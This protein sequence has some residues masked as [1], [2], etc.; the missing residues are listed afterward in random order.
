MKLGIIS[1]IRY[2]S[3]ASTTKTGLASGSAS[4]L[5]HRA[6]RRFNKVHKPDA[7]VIFGDMLENY[8]VPDAIEQLEHLKAILA[9]LQCPHIVMPGKQD[10]AASEFH[11]VF[12]HQETYWELKGV[13]LCPVS[14]DPTE[15]ESDITR[16]KMARSAF[17]G[18]IAVLCTGEKVS[19]NLQDERGQRTATKILAA[20][21]DNGIGI[22]LASHKQLHTGE[23]HFLS[24]LNLIPCPSL[25]T[26][27][28]PMKILDIDASGN[29]SVNSDELP[30]PAS[31]RLYDW[32]V[33]S[34]FAYCSENMDFAKNMAFAKEMGLAGFCQLEH[35][36]QLYYD[37][38]SYCDGHCH[39]A[40]L[41]GADPKHGRMEAFLKAANPFIGDNVRLG[42]EVDSDSAARPILDKKAQDK[43]SVLAA[44]VHSFTPLSEQAISD[45]S[46]AD[47][48]LGFNDKFLSHGFDFLAHPF[49]VYAR[50]DKKPPQRIFRPLAK[51]LKKH[52]T[53]A[54][55]N[56]HT[57]DPPSEFFQIC[58]EEGVRLVLGSDSHNLCE[59][60]ELAPHLAML[61]S[62]GFNGDLGDILLDFKLK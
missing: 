20:M 14:L 37:P 58:L 5:M 4:I 36:G 40:G 19:Q 50:L 25:C 62:I 3:G 12:P 24:G 47:G 52:K 53:A 51:L 57:D 54:E 30:M 21:R 23:P 6:I 17:K 8:H 31:L 34:P 44:S 13:R 9:K 59:I 32:H 55:L 35:S 43:A 11:K 26:R 45:D 16:L 42:F 15:L 1:D 7:V 22:C 38:H 28:Y 2:G 33:H 60:G 41:A 18:A 48:F 61:R 39:S 29:C 46:A 10:A 49:R 56:F 27:P